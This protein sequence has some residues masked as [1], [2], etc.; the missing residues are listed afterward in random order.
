MVGV[1]SNGFLRYSRL[2]VY[3]LVPHP[4]IIGECGYEAKGVYRMAPKYII[5]VVIEII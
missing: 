4:H 2:E 3:S 5:I 1:A